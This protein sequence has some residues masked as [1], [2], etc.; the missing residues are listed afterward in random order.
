[1]WG[2]QRA[3]Q[4]YQD[5]RR[6]HMHVPLYSSPTDAR[7]RAVVRADRSP[8]AL[9]VAELSTRTGCL[10]GGLQSRGEQAHRGPLPSGWPR[11]RAIPRHHVHGPIHRPPAIGTRL[12]VTPP[13]EV[14]RWRALRCQSA[15]GCG[16]VRPHWQ[17]RRL[18]ECTRQEKRELT[19]CAGEGAR[20][21][22]AGRSGRPHLACGRAHALEHPTAQQATSRSDVQHAGGCCGQFGVHAL[23]TTVA[24]FE[25]A[26]SRVGM[27]S[28]RRLRLCLYSRACR[29]L[30]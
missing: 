24:N 29:L 11:S 7:C 19:P 20:P 23:G 28:D 25:V 18:D 22:I 14:D 2:R 6:R 13:Q 16:G 15:P 3:L 12:G 27:Q 9:L 17:G 5:A 4:P 30:A 8:A 26:E 10:V 1:M 21:L